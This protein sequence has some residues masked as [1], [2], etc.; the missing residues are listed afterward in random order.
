MLKALAAEYQYTAQRK[1]GLKGKV[2]GHAE[3]ELSSDPGNQELSFQ[4]ARWTA[5]VFQSQLLNAVDVAP[6]DFQ[7]EIEGM[8]TGFCMGDP[9]CRGKVRPE[10]LAQYRR[11]DVL[12]FTEKML[13]PQIVTCPPVSGAG[14]KTLGEYIELVRCA[15][16]AAELKAG[17][18]P[19]KCWRCSVRCIMASRGARPR[20]I[21]SGTS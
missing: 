6:F 10:A 13:G 3:V 9:D 11:A 8:G 12:I 15:E 2:I 14:V 7:F 19:E 17:Y 18:Y 16:V 5:L 1:G 20:R 21:R 4:R